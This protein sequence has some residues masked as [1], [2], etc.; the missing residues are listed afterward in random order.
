LL[1]AEVK[2]ALPDEEH[3]R[4]LARLAEIGATAGPPRHQSDVYLSH[5][6]RDFAARDEALRLRVD[7][8][9]LRLTWKGPKLDPPRK[10]R[11]EIEFGLATDERT[12]A[13]LFDRLGFRPVATVAKSRLEWRLPG[14]GGVLVSVDEVEGLGRFCEVEVAAEDVA[15]GREALD[16]ALARLGLGGATPIA[17]SYLELLLRRGP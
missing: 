5:P 3:R 15:A 14:P 2:L 17:E 12:A 10:T 11:E 1:E 9:R 4:L 16:D 7:D 8:D 6:S 13:L